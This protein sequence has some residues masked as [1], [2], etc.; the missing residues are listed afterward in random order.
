MN[1]KT[2]RYY[3]LTYLYKRERLLPLNTVNLFGELEQ[4]GENII[5]PCVARGE[6]KIIK[7]YFVTVGA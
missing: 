2:I 6:I 3:M 7:L 5:K 1:D 4:S